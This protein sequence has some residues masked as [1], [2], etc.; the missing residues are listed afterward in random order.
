MKRALFCKG[1]T[2]G[3]GG[4]ELQREKREKWLRKKG[5]K[6]GEVSGRKKGVKGLTSGSTTT[7][8]RGAAG[9]ILI[10]GR[11]FEENGS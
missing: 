3:G 5:G 9:K 4:L 8:G 1:G 10:S 11:S 7:G 6:Q 2:G